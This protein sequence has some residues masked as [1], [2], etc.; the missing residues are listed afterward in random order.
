MS[1]ELVD[2]IANSEQV[3]FQGVFEDI[4]EIAHLRLM[5]DV[6]NILVEQEKVNF[7]EVIL[8]TKKLT[9][10]SREKE[11][12]LAGDEYRG[13]YYRLPESKYF[14]FYLRELYVYSDTNIDTTLKVFDINDESELFS[15]DISLTAGLNTISVDKKFNLKY[16]ILDLFIGVDCSGFN[17]IKTLREYYDWYDE[18]LACIS[19]CNSQNQIYECY[20]ARLDKNLSASYGNILKDGFGRG[21]AVGSEIG[22]DIEEF[23]CE[24]RKKLIGSL[25]FLLG[26]VTLQFKL[27]SPRLNLFTTS[28]LAITEETKA[29]FE[30]QYYSNLKRVLKTIPVKGLCFN[31]DDTLDVFTKGSIA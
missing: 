23:I 5:D 8:Q 21:I 3:T 26:S 11:E 20:P 28:N 29:D 17:S 7:N 19:P 27:N 4:Q 22:C 10:F 31:C 18:D 16:G 14:Y 6:V 25:L 24:N 13:V 15:L 2:N 12:I 1:S 30:K 9:K